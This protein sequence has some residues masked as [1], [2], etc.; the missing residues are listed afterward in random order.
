MTNGLGIRHCLV[1]LIAVAAFVLA[2]C[3]K[4]DDSSGGQGKGTTNAGK[5]FKIAGIIMQDDE[6]FHMVQFGMEDASAKAG[7]DFVRGNSNGKPEKEAELINTYVGQHVDAIVI[8]PISKTLSVQVLKTAADKGIKIV[9]QNNPLNADF[10]VAVIE[11]DQVDLG[12]QTG[13]EAA[14]YIREK[15]GG[16]ARIA[17][18]AFKSQVPE[19]SNDRVNGFKA[20]VQ[21]LP[22]VQIVAEQDAWKYDQAVTKVGDIITAHP[23]VNLIWAANEGGTYG[24]VLAVRNGNKAGKI[25]VFGTDASEQLVGCLEA[26]DNI[27]QAIT[28]QKPAEVGSKAVEDAVKALKG[29]PIDNK[30]EI[31]KGICLTRTNPQGIADFKKQLAVWMKKDK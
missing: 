20:E 14:Q 24:S 6:F 4:P 28:S 26:S 25:V 13:K 21:K 22:G 16:N 12:T 19:Q 18:L 5:K 3:S 17:I 1:G 9:C 8:S 11:S 2:G 31:L 27:L 7:V 15:M 29:E 10:P 30:K 23:D